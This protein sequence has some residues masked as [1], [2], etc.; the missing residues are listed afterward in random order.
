MIRCEIEKK[1]VEAK[2]VP[3]VSIYNDYMHLNN[4]PSINGIDLIGN[5]TAT[6]LNLLTSNIAVYTIERIEEIKKDAFMLA[7]TEDKHVFK[8]S[9]EDITVGR[10]ITAEA[11]PKEMRI[12]SYVFLKK[13]E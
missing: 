11:L 2:V 3:N 8:I 13:E 7:L 4:K 10:F 1:V 12:G 9:L 6:E 5:K